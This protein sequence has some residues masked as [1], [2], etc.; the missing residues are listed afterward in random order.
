MVMHM[1]VE[2]GTEAVDEANRPEAG[3]RT[4]TAALAQM[5]LDDKQKDSHYGV[6]GARLALQVPAQPFRHL[7]AG[8]GC[9]HRGTSCTASLR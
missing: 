4:G 9:G 6:E 3:L 5:G 7:P 1:A 8:P 2:R